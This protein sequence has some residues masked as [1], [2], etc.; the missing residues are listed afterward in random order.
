MASVGEMGQP[1]D[2][3]M[4]SLPPAPRS[5]EPGSDCDLPRRFPRRPLKTQGCLQARD[6]AP[7][8]CLCGLQPGS[9]RSAP[10]FL[11]LLLGMRK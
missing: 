5:P 9:L 11:L 6:T 2:W 3:Q 7:S 4:D 10:P 8:L 1:A